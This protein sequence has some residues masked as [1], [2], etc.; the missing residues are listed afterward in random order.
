MTPVMIIGYALIVIGFIGLKKTL[1]RL[2][3]TDRKRA[4]MAILAGFIVVYVGTPAVP[5]EEQL[6]MTC[7]SG[8][9]A[10]LLAKPKGYDPG[11]VVINADK[12]FEVNLTVKTRQRDAYGDTGVILNHDAWCRGSLAEGGKGSGQ[13]FMEGWD[14]PQNWDAAKYAR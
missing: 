1:P 3:I 8:F 13:L 9:D 5:K 12:T 7:R 14:G 10:K 2:E 4:G 11:I 6:A